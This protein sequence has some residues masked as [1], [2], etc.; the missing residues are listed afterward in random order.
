MCYDWY[1]TLSD[2]PAW[3][4]GCCVSVNPSVLE[5]AVKEEEQR[6]QA[7][8]EPGWNHDS[9]HGAWRARSG[10]V[11]KRWS[12]VVIQTAAVRVTGNGQGQ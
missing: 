6:R 7:M 4:L 5:P 2:V 3:L 11:G 9:I 12:I 8:A 10:K 1:R